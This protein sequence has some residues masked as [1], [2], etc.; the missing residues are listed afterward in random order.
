MTTTERIEIPLSK[1]KLTR[2]LIGSVVF[3]LIGL[4]ILIY[5]PAISNSVFINPLIKYGAAIACILFFGFVSIFYAKKLTDKKPGLIIDNTGITDNS[6]AVSVG[7]TPWTDIKYITTIKVV[8]QDF[9]IL[10]VENP[11]NYINKQTNIIKRKTMEM[12]FKSYGSPIN[13]SANSLKS[14]FNE[15]KS[16][17][18]NKLAEF[19]SKKPMT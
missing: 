4:W 18:D 19:K 13:I 2:G 16:V 3:V 6:S 7:H 14:N 8:K 12:N 1:T 17:L 5:Q 11:N 9:I 15:L 10:I